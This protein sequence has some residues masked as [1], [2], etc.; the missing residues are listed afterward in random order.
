MREIYLNSN[1]TPKTVDEIKVLALYYDKIHVVN[2]CIYRVGYDDRK[3]ELI[4]VDL[5]FIPDTFKDDYHVLLEEGVLSITDGD[6]IK[7]KDRFSKEI[8]EIVNSN[9]DFIFPIDKDKPNTRIITEEVYDIINSL[10][11]YSPDKGFDKQFV[12]WYYAF[13]LN[14]SLNL[15]LKGANCM[16]GSDNLNYLFKKLIEKLSLSN[17]LYGNKGYSK[18]I[19]V[20]AI[21]LKLPNPSL[22]SFDD[23][24]ELKY[25]LSDELLEFSSLINS[26]ESKN[27][28]LFGELE[29]SDEEYSAIF[30]NEIQKPLK[31]L[32]CNLKNLN[33]KSFRGLIKNMQNPRSYIPLIGTVVASLPVQY[34]LLAS[35][36]VIA[37]QSYLEYKE[38]HRYLTNNNGLYFL[39]KI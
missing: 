32:E 19:A 6:E 4:R 37:G 13:K 21:K 8:S 24:L 3:N 38:E 12:W 17:E 10:N 35:L 25:R 16:N 15:L 23:V 27:K 1:I 5:D 33:S 18:S 20:D 36:G 34:L 28:N 9:E 26:I 2:D 14:W 31:D 7:N 11:K 39:L 22:L 30:Y 29:V